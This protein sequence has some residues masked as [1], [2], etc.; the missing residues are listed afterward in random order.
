MLMKTPQGN[1]CLKLGCQYRLW[2][3]QKPEAKEI[4]KLRSKDKGK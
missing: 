2:T 1:G 4:K 3:L